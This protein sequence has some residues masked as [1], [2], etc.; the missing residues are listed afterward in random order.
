WCRRRGA[1]DAADACQRGSELVGVSSRD[2]Q[3][4]VAIAGA[5]AYATVHGPDPE[6][7]AGDLVRRDDDLPPP[8]ACA[9]AETEEPAVRDDDEP[10]AP[11]HTHA[12]DATAGDREDAF[13]GIEHG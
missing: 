5:N 11:E 4:Q 13:V 2:E 6:C 9:R 10:G 8:V 1:R 7:D 3:A 12:S